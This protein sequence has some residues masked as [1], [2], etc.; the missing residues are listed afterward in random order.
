MATQTS[1]A[2]PSK[3]TMNI[4]TLAAD[5]VSAESRIQGLAFPAKVFVRSINCPTIR[6]AATIRMVENNCRVVRNVRSRRRTSVK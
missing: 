3:G 2:A 6:F 1:F 5:R 4:R